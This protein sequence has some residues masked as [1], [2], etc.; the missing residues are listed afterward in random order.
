MRDALDKEKNIGMKTETLQLVAG[1]R[2]ETGSPQSRRLRRD[3]WIPCVMYGGEAAPKMLKVN[4][5]DLEMVIQ[6]RGGQNII[7][8]MVVDGEATGNVLLKDLQRDPVTDR[9]VHADF[10][11]VSMTKKLR[12][13]VTVRLE[14]EPVGVSQHGGVL[15]HQARSV[16][17]ECLPSDIV[18][19]F[20]LDASGLDIDDRLHVRDIEADPT[21]T[22]LTPEDAVIASVHMPRL[23]E[24]ETKPE[25][26]AAEEGAAP[27]AGEGEE[28]GEAASGSESPSAGEG[29]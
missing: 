14:G 16:E 26:A 29:K 12:V 17:V 1:E 2:T 28:K 7:F 21:L 10:L 22:I 25:E 3:G 5:H 24:E 13:T 9:A 18:E 8:N 20:V 27:G 19:E 11:Q 23:E 15:E 4:R 6:H